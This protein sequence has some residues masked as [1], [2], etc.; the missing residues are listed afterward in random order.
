MG[1]PV[2]DLLRKLDWDV[3]TAKQAKLTGKI[4]D[5]VWVIYAREN[6][7]IGVTFDELRAK[8]G[9][10]IAS[11]LILRGGKL[12]RIQGGPEQH[13]FRA[14]GKLL[15][16]YEKWYMFLSE[17]DGVSVISDTK[18]CRNC[19][20]E[21]YIQHYHHVEA[22]QFSDYLNHYKQ[23]PYIKRSRKPKPK[24]NEQGLLT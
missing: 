7:R 8:Q 4:N 13:P 24:P 20:P 5:V 12:I 22:E 11:E 18:Q 16:H 1:K 6:F 14:I 9:L 2:I 15:F 21:Q 17:H 3:Q 10:D 23:R 19:T